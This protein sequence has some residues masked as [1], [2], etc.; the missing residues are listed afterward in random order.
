M[1]VAEALSRTDPSCAVTY[2]GRAGGPEAGI[3]AE[4]GLDFVGLT[5]GSM[6][7]SR[8]TATPRLLTRLPLAYAQASRVVSRFRPDVVLA[9]GGYVS[10]PVALV[11]QRRHIPLLL[12]EQ[13]ALPGRAVSWLA[14][15]AS[16]VATSFPETVQHLVAAR[17]V[18]TGNPVRAEFADLAAPAIPTE[19]PPG[20]LVMGGSQGAR[21]LNDL[22]LEALPQLMTS[23]PGMPIIH[24]TGPGDYSRVVRAAAALQLPH[25][26]LYQPLPFSDRM[27][28]LLARVG[29]VVMRAGGSSLAEAA[30]LGKPMLL[31]PYPHAG[32]HQLANAI[33]FAEAGAAVVVDDSEMSAARLVTEVSGILGSPDRWARM[34]EASCGM[35]RPGAAEAVGALLR[36]LG[37]GR[38]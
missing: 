21:H 28:S 32:N 30:C 8:L 22:L 12:L 23:R 4:A 24:L 3:V 26:A 29:L 16:V 18:C 6:G 17:T 37:R 33:P 20:L 19:A 13:N 35:A 14:G 25:S 27:A 9:T 36:E 31:V 11:A 15:R 7:S 10:V 2:V 34:A 38:R 5:L 1:A